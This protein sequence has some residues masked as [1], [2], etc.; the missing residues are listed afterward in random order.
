MASRRKRDLNDVSSL[1]AALSKYGLTHG[2]DTESL[3]RKTKAEQIQV[4]ALMEGPWRDDE[5]VSK[6]DDGDGYHSM[7]YN[8]PRMEYATDEA[9]HRAA[10]IFS[11]V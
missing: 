2:G 8:M 10:A 7:L 11:Q 3:Y 1:H 5:M 6:L 4:L 9:A